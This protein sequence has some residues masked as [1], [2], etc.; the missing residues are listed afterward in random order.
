MLSKS[1]LFFVV[2]ALGLSACQT[3]DQA[4]YSNTSNVQAEYSRSGAKADP[5]KGDSDEYICTLGINR[6]PLGWGTDEYAKE[7]QR[8][9]LTTE[10]CLNIITSPPRQYDDA[11]LNQ[12]YWEAKRQECSEKAMRKMNFS[13]EV[14]NNKCDCAWGAINKYISEHDRT[15][16]RKLTQ[17][18]LTKEEKS[19]IDILDLSEKL[20]EAWEMASS[21][22]DLP[23]RTNE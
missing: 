8:R 16:M 20:G 10:Q 11:E 2:F 4:R 17:R 21:K 23:L 22:C 15:I 14:A 5:L 3:T 7:A 12:I 1:S 19:Q 6:D 9:G 18:R 13:E